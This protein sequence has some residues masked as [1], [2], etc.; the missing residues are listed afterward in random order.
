[1]K[2]IFYVF[3]GLD[4]DEIQTHGDEQAARVAAETLCLKG[5]VAVV[6]RLVARYEPAAK[7]REVD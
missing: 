2:L 5:R 3:D 4:P 7:V 6:T 1:M